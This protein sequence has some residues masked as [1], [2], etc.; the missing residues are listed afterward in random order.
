M[1]STL[2]RSRDGPSLQR[3]GSGRSGPR[4]WRAAES[5]IARP[6]PQDERGPALRRGAHTRGQVSFHTSTASSSRSIARRVGCCQLQPCRFS[7][8]PGQ[9]VLCLV[10]GMV[11]VKGAPQRAGREWARKLMS[12]TGYFRCWDCER[13]WTIADGLAENPDGARPQHQLTRVW[14]DTDESAA[15]VESTAAG[16]TG[17][18]ATRFR[19]DGNALLADDGTPWGRISVFSDSAPGSFGG[20]NSLTVVSRPGQPTLVA[21]AGDR[22]VVCLWDAADGRLV[23]GPRPGHPDRV[24]SMTVVPL[25]DAA[26]F[27]RAEATPGRSPCGI[28]SQGGP[29]ANRPATG[30]VG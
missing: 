11:A 24:C 3:R 6:H 5:W 7:R 9:A 18:A 30:P 14:T 21:G 17:E 10:A 25:P 29:L 19:R 20:V 15:T 28:R 27:W 16:R 8:R 1:P 26:S 2:A 12:L 23:H 4:S 13:T 22:G